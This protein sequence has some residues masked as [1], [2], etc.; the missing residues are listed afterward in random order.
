MLRQSRHSRLA[1]DRRRAALVGAIGVCLFATGQALAAS[2]DSIRIEAT[3][4]QSTYRIGDRIEYVVAVEWKKPVELVGIEP[5]VEL[6]VF[7]ILQAPEITEEKTRRGWRRRETR[8]FLSTFETGEFTIPTFTVVYRDAGG[9]RRVGTPPVKIT[10]E[11]VAPLREDDEGIRDA[12]PPVLPPWRMSKEMALAL[13]GAALA[14]TI[15]AG[16]LIALWIRKRRL[17]P[18]PTAPPRPIEDV[19]REA[20]TRIAQSDLLSQGL[21]KEYFDQV[22]DVIRE[23]L[24]RRYGFEGIAT[25]TSELLEALRGPL[26]EDGR[27][28]LVAAFSDDADLAKFARWQPDRLVCDRFLDTAHRVIDETT[29]KT[30]QKAE[31]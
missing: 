27:L 28:K 13:A 1:H 23:Y 14:L 9:E 29:E 8:Y 4:A 10:V 5:S 2:T 3:T 22:S 19:A 26:S 24:G 17:E 30:I 11:S 7:E 15:L 16:V 31:G 21:I 6:N 25:T 18:V 12:K 20:L